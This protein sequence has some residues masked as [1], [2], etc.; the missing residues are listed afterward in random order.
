MVHTFHIAF[1]LGGYR[2]TSFGSSYAKYFIEKEN[3]LIS[4]AVWKLPARMAK[5]YPGVPFPGQHVTVVQA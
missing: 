5:H 3:N 4:R 2:S 1:K